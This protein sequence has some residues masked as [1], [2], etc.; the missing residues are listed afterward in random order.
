MKSGVPRG[1]FL[2]LTLFL[3]FINDL[4]LFMNYCSSDFFADDATL[5]AHDNNPHKV[6]EKL[7]CGQNSMYINY[8]K[9]N[10][11]ILGRTNKQNV[12]QE[13]DIIID[14]KHQIDAKP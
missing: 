13:F 2:G 12:P 8:D 9:T 10:Y 7:Q 1:S 14:D 11:M 3:L 4:P 6:E 5:H